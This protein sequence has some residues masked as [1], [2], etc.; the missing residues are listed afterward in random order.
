MVPIFDRIFGHKVY[1]S[2][3]IGV[4]S[5]LKIKINL[6]NLNITKLNYVH[7]KQILEGVDFVKTINSMISIDETSGRYLIL[8]LLQ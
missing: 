3:L 2:N 8:R 7:A 4:W 5:Y 6:F 1:F